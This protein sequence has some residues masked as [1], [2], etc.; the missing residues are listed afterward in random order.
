LKSACVQSLQDIDI[1]VADGRSLDSSIAGIRAFSERDSRVRYFS[2]TERLGIH[3]N[4]IGAVWCSTGTFVQMLDAC[5]ELL[6]DTIRHDF[7]AAIIQTADM[8]GHLAIISWRTGK[9]SPYYFKLPPFMTVNSSV[10]TRTFK[11]GKVN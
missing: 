9:R 3:G 2:N 10:L 6:N 4:H 7:E 8:V 11:S 1:L 5:D